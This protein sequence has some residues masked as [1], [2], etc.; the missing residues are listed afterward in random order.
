ME[1]IIIGN[2]STK[3]SVANFTFVPRFLRFDEVKL[4]YYFGSMSIEEKCRSIGNYLQPLKEALK[5]VNS[6]R[7][8]GVID[9]DNYTQFSDHSKL[10]NHLSEQLL[11]FSIR[12]VDTTFILIS[13][14][15]KQK[16]KQRLLT[17]LYKCLKFVDAQPFVLIFISLLNHCYCPSRQFQVG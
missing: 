10:L 11:K 13:A 6:I 4:S 9:P 3:V 1:A 2:T 7:F 12:P 14:L 15:K 8:S 5:D 17:Q 16:Q